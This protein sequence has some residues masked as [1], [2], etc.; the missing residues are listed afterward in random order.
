MAVVEAVN[1]TQDAGNQMVKSLVVLYLL[2]QLW[3]SHI[4]N[5][6]RAP[7]S[8]SAARLLESIPVQLMSYMKLLS[9]MGAIHVA[10]R[11][12]PLGSVTLTP[13]ELCFSGEY[14]KRFWKQMVRPSRIVLHLLNNEEH[15][16]DNE[17]LTGICNQFADVV[18]SPPPRT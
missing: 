12:V 9:T 1:T 3:L 13:N 11:G 16:A 17:Q 18:D 2:I 7:V 8:L 10:G 4:A 14:I 5:R 6:L 15:A